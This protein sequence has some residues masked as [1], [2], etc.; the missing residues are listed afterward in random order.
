MGEAKGRGSYEE[1][2]KKAI[3]EGTNHPKKKHITQSMIAKMSIDAALTTL[4]SIAGMPKRRKNNAKGS[5]KR[6]N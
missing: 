2:K 3:K 4:F 1:R 5:I 6:P